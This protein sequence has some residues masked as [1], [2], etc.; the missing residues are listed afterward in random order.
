MNDAWG[1]KESLEKAYLPLSFI[2]GDLAMVASEGGNYL[3][4]IGP[5]GNGKMTAGSKKILNGMADWM[6][7]NSASIY[8]VSASP[9]KKDPAWGTYTRKNKTVYAHVCKWPKK[10]ELVMKRYQK[11]KFRKLQ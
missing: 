2:I 3:L 10:G 8:G 5:K 7:K 11:K 6:K 1:Y 9:F 4:N